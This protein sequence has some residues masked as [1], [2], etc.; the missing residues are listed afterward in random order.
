MPWHSIEQTT[1]LNNIALAIVSKF[2]SP[3]GKELNGEWGWLTTG[4]IKHA[5][6]VLVSESRLYNTCV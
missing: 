6:V 3:T 2:P 1:Q 5:A 4:L